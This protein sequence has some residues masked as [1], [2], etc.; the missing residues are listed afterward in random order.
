VI[1]LLPEVRLP[2]VAVLI[3]RLQT[4]DD[5]KNAL[6]AEETREQPK[7]P[8]SRAQVVHGRLL[9]RRF[10]Q[11]RPP[12]G[13]TLLRSRQPFEHRRPLL[14]FLHRRQSAV[15]GDAVH[16]G[17]IVVAVAPQILFRDFSHSRHLA[18]GLAL[19]HYN[20][21][22]R[23][24]SVGEILA[25]ISVFSNARNNFSTPISH[26]SEN[27]AGKISVARKLFSQV[28]CCG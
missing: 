9:A 4:A 12:I 20:R 21:T 8:H 7:Q 24:F 15:Q 14:F 23:A 26:K 22:F 18:V 6:R 10:E 13:V 3:F 11:A 25:P 16:L 5:R 27:D 19:D 28:D 2:R 17:Q 1:S